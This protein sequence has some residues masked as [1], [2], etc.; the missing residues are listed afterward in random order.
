MLYAKLYFLTP[1]ALRE[2]FPRPKVFAAIVTAVLTAVALA[3]LQAIGLE[4]DSSV[5]LLDLVAEQDLTYRQAVN[6]VL[7]LVAAYLT[8][9]ARVELLEGEPA[10]REPADVDI[11]EGEV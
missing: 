5:P 9:E 3:V 11:V 2:R 8:S 4:V 7:P 1:E 10:D 6:V